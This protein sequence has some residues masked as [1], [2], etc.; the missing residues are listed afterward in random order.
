MIRH[1]FRVSFGIVIIIIGIA[2]IFLPLIPGLLLILVGVALVVDKKPKVLWS[3]IIAQ[4]KARV[5]KKDSQK[6]I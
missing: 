4:L 5:K 3:E 2:G 1:I 6:C